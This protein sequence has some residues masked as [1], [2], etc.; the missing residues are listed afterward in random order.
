[1]E[2]KISVI[3]PVYKVEK[4]LHRCID[5]ILSQSFTDFELILV[6]DGSPDNCGKICDEYAQKDSRVRVFHKPNGGVS[7][8]RNLGLDNAKGEWIFF[9]DADD[10]LLPNA[11]D[12]LISHIDPHIAYVMAG[13]TKSNEEGD[14]IYC[15]DAKGEQVISKTDAITQMFHSTDFQYQG[16][17]WNKL[18]NYS[19]ISQNQLRFAEDIYFNEDRLFN[20]VY[21][22]NIKDKK[23]LYTTLPV[24]NY[25]YRENSA[26]YLLKRSYNPKFATDL[27]AFLQA[28]NLLKQSGDEKNIEFCKQ[29]AYH[30]FRYNLYMMKQFNSYDEV[31][32]KQMYS[33]LREQLTLGYIVGNY[34]KDKINTI[35]S[36]LYKSCI[37]K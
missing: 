19:I 2:P 26:M 28:L 13:Y 3:V 11:F 35:K 15:I 10:E 29:A 34:L 23:C 18:Y 6:D 21:L 31:L 20:I 22:L 8:A 1:M 14:I 7:S 27:Y 5:S 30:S 17:L 9:S 4:Y 16:Y 37:I 12:I 32:A 25:V 33:K 36:K 24:Y